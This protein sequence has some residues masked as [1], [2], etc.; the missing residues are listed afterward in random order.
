MKSCHHGSEKV[1]DAFLDA[2]NPAAFIISSGDEEG[3][4]HPRPDLL[5]RGGLPVILSTELQRSSRAMENK[6]SVDALMAGI[7]N[8]RPAR[9]RKSRSR[10]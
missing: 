5:G 2:V 1:T 4:I 7:D 9:S 3:H 10:S 8:W 6:N